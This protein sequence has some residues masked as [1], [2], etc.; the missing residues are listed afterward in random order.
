M[1]FSAAHK[2]AGHVRLIKIK[3]AKEI[4][5]RDFETLLVWGWVESWKSRMRGI[6]RVAHKT[7]R[8]VI[9]RQRPTKQ[10][11]YSWTQKK[12][13]KITSSVIWARRKCRPNVRPADGVG[14]W[15]LL[16]LLM[17]QLTTKK[18]T[19][20]ITIS[21][22]AAPKLKNKK[23]RASKSRSELLANYVLATTNMSARINQKPFFPPLGCSTMPK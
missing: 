17:L 23:L 14:D 22:V 15:R 13:K 4:C 5:G 21:A 20:E 16:M 9:S 6:K 19:V 12:Y 7:L 2:S 8:Q 1:F 18:P 11:L 3:T 10:I